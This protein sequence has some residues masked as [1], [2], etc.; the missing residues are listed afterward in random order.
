MTNAIRRA[1]DDPVPLE[2]P[3][4]G[5]WDSISARSQLEEAD[6]VTRLASRRRVAGWALGAAAA[7][8][9]VVA[10]VVGIAV[11]RDGDSGTVVATA[12]LDL[13]EGPATGSAELVDVDGTT[14]LVVELDAQ[15]PDDGFLEVWLLDPDVSR[16]HS[17]GPVRSD[18]T[19]EIP[20]GLVVAEVPVVDVSVE[21]F[22]GD[23]GHSGN[24]VL[25]GVLQP[26]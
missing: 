15:E 17:L 18:G 4:D 21:S 16:L 3:P 8:I 20:S 11:T 25:R 23:P 1:I 19:Y 10:L 24:S 14:R 2:S 12:Q 13:I 6:N 26:I 5:L 9:V 22:D 7:V